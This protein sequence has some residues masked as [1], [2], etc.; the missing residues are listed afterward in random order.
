VIQGPASSPLAAKPCSVSGST[1]TY[2][3]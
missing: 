1:V 2:G 3:T